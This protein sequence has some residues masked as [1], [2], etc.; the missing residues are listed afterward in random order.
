[1]KVSTSLDRPILSPCG[2]KNLDYQVDTY[3]GCEHLCHYCYV[4]EHAE[5]DWSKEIQIHQNIV[6]QLIEKIGGIAPQKIYMGYQTDPY[7]PRDEKYLQSRK[8]LA[9]FLEKG[10]SASILTKSDLVLRDI[11]IL[12]EMKDAA[13]SVSVAFNDDPTRRLFEAHTVANEKRVDALCQLKEADIQ[14]GALVC[15]VIPYITNAIPLIDILAPCTDEI[16]I[17]GLSIKDRSGK[18]WVNIQS[19][20]KIHFPDLAEQI[21]QVIFSKE[22]LYWIQLREKL[23]ALKNDLKLNLNIHL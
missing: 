23:T 21:E 18:N 7:Q 1:M 20:L 17:Y 9:L 13:I 14:T 6:A 10:F 22:H 4:L 2:L 16:W 5:T 11:D 3:V 15:P 19:I 8:V 12:K